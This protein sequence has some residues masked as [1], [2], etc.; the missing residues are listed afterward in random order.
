MVPLDARLDTLPL[1]PGVYL[2]KD[3][4]GR[5]LYVGKAKSLKSRV[6]Q[7][8]SGHDGRV[9]V[10][11]LVRAAHDVEVIVVRTEKEALILENTLIKKHEPRYNTK[12]VD[13]T[14]FLHLRI[15][16]DGLWPHYSVVRGVGDKNARHFGPYTSASRARATIEFLSRRFPLRTCSDRELQSRRRPCLLHQ[17]HRCLAPC[18]GLCTQAEYSEVV[19]QSVLFLEGRN[20]ELIDRL[21]EQMMSLAEAEDFESAARLRDLIRAIEASIERQQVSDLRGGDRDA[22]GVFREGDGGVVTLMPVRG[23][24]LQE[25]VNLP[26]DAVVEDD[27]ELLSSVLNHWYQEGAY[28]P[29]EILTSVELADAAA[30]LELLRERHAGPLQLSCPAEGDARSLVELCIG[31]ARTTWTRRKAAVDRNQQ[32][33]DELM[34]VA[35]L[36]KLPRRI[37][38]FDNSNI[39][40]TDPVASMV[41]FVD[42]A[43]A[44]AEYR[45]YKVKDVIGADD[46]ATMHEILGRRFRRA[47]EDGVFPDLLVVDGGKGQLSVALAVLAELGVTTV[48]AI[49]LSKPRT[50]RARGDR[51]TPDKIVLPNAKNPIVLKPNSPALHL[52]QALRDETHRTAVRYHRKVRDRRTLTSALEALP[53]VGKVRSRNLLRHF[54]SMTKLVQASA[55]DIGAVPGI[56]PELAGV[57]H[58][59]L[60]RPVVDG[61]PD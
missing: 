40:G 11:F 32:A 45:R 10:P 7:Y 41:V 43:P 13:D 19:D 29:A 22:W 17:M 5:V 15:D 28:F 34:R 12:L 48:P 35:H 39:Q 49:G 9:M 44:K 36:P 6:K 38:C 1:D 60:C 56:G 14:S 52:L 42:G 20:R 18:V 23:G 47:L 2:F 54:G 51:D 25:A 53:G 8:F 55:E 30:L 31:N 37:E 16:P 4:R 59:L 27:G 50:E 24:L 58:A 61:K 21:G 57:I 33:M 46:Y 3:S 26:F